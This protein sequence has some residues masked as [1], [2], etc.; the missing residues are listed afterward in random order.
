MRAPPAAASLGPP[1]PET[2]TAGSSARSSRVKA[3]AYR[4]PD[5]S[6]H[7]SSSF[8]ADCRLR[9]AESRRRTREE[10]G[11]DRLID[12]DADHAPIDGLSGGPSRRV[13]RN[14]QAVDEAVIRELLLDDRSRRRVADERL[15]RD[16]AAGG[17]DLQDDWI[18]VAR[19]QLDRVIRFAER[20]ADV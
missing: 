16:E 5:A 8:I 1:S 12:R 11:I 3:P 2:A 13:K 18:E 7:D 17:I 10:R 20:V 4:S 6:P 14:L 15:L 9:I 19:R